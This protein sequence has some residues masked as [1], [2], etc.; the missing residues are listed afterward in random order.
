MF[1]RATCEKLSV[2]DHSE[3]RETYNRIAEED[4]VS[5]RVDAPCHT[6][7]RCLD[8]EQRGS[9]KRQLGVEKSG[10]MNIPH[11]LKREIKRT[12]IFRRLRTED[13]TQRSKLREQA[14]NS[15]HSHEATP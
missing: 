14:D 13:T 6:H 12:P 10:L 5:K 15:G 4:T 11:V 7:R 2:R 8:D 3:K 9:H 1:C